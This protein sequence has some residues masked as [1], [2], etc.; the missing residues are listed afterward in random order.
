MDMIKSAFL[1]N[2]IRQKYYPE[3]IPIYAKGRL[4]DVGCGEKPLLELI[5]PYV[6]SYIG[7]DIPSTLHKKDKIDIFGSALELPF[8]NN[9]F[10]TV[11]CKGVLEHL[12]EPD[13]VISEIGR[14]LKNDGY[15]ILSTNLLYHLHEEPYDFYRYTKHGLRYLFEKNKFQV[16]KITATSGFWVTFG[17]ESTYYLHRFNRVVF[18]K[19]IIKLVCGLFQRVA[20]LIDMFNK[21]EEFTMGYIVVSQ[22]S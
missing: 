7:L 6:E 9:S 17:H 20:Y 18:L 21:A 11:F 12:P 19:W 1:I 4:L 2:K 16:V 3:L 10:D 13:K 15:C 22:R 14:V 5:T 8:Q